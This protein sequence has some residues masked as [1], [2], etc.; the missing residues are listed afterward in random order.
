MAFP[1]WVN[2]QGSAQSTTTATSVT[3]TLPASVVAGRLLVAVVAINGVQAS[4]TATSGWTV[5]G[6]T[7]YSGGTTSSTLAVFAKIATGT[8]ALTVTYPT[9]GVA[10]AL[11][12]QFADATMTPTLG[13]IT[14]VSSNAPNPPAQSGEITFEYLG[15]AVLSSAN[16]ATTISTYPSGSTN[17]ASQLAG[18]ASLV[19]QRVSTAVTGQ[20]SNTADPGAFTLSAA[21][22]GVVGTLL[23]KGTQGAATPTRKRGMFG[24]LMGAA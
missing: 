20:V 22:A 13:A 1:S 24:P 7:T 18:A 2:Q 12:L 4:V 10:A 8:D 3:P 5:I 6:R 15:V 17:G 23:I 16:G 14:F 11:L 21:D 9:A 19:G